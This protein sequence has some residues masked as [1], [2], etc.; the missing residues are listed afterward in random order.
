MFM[1]YSFSSLP[2]TSKNPPKKLVLLIR[3]GT[4]LAAGLMRMA[5]DSTGTIQTEVDRRRTNTFHASEVTAQEEVFAF[6]I[7]KYCFNRQVAATKR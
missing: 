7:W 3:D 4:C 6:V 5:A 1:Q 2:P